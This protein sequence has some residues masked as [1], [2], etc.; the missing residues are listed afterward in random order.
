MVVKTLHKKVMDVKNSLNRKMS[1]ISFMFA[2]FFVSYKKDTSKVKER[3]DKNFFNPLFKNIGYSPDSCQD[4][5]KLI[6]S[7]TRSNL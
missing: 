7:F 2:T 5:D 1:C 3:Q 6:C 4:S